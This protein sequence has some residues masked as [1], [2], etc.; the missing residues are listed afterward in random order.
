MLVEKTE[1][2]VQIISP[3]ELL[4]R[5]AFSFPYGELAYPVRG[6]NIG[7]CGTI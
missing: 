5:T 2:K 6:R 4:L 1:M 3:M 7:L